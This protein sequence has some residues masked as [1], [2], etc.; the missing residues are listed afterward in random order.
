MAERTETEVLRVKHR[1]G[2]GQR[3]DAVS[4]KATR[5]NN[6][7]WTVLSFWLAD[8]RDVDSDSSVVLLDELECVLGAG[9]GMSTHDH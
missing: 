7:D 2:Q 8:V 4:G 5:Y 3:R 1:H 9:E 6:T